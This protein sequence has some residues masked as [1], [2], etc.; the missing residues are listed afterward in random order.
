MVLACGTPVRGML[1]LLSTRYHFLSG[2]C[3]TKGFLTSNPRVPHA[4]N[5]VL[6][7]T[8]SEMRI[9]RVV[10]RSPFGRVTSCRVVRF[11]PGGSV[12][13]FGSLLGIWILFSRLDGSR[14]LGRPWE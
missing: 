10:G 12:R 1:R 9:R 6:Y 2:C 14:W 7:Q 5:I 4:K 11:R 8:A 3:G 13:K